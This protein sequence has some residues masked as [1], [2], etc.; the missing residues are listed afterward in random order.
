MILV[1]QNK[2]DCHI[3]SKKIR[4]SDDDNHPTP[5][6]FFLLYPDHNICIVR[7]GILT[8]T[9]RESCKKPI[10]LCGFGDRQTDTL[11]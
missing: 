4:W 7:G 3:L 2:M 5:S 11:T 8:I 1:K 6:S 9:R 10:N